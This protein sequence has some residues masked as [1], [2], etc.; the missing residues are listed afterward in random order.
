MYA[1]KLFFLLF[2]IKRTLKNLRIILLIQL[3]CNYSKYNCRNR[4]EVRQL[5]N[6]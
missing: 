3:S 1:V 2:T 5:V 4:G 6:I